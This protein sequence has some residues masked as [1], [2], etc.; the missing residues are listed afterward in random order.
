MKFVK[1]ALTLGLASGLLFGCTNNNADRGKNNVSPV[2]YNNPNTNTDNTNNMDRVSYQ[3][4]LGPGANVNYRDRDNNL[5]VN[6]DNT[7]GVNRDNNL[8]TDVN[9]NR[10]YNNRSNYRIAKEAADRVSKL[11]EVRRAN[12][13]VTGNNAYVAV[14]LNDRSRN[15]LPKTFENKISKE[16]K[17]ADNTIDNVY[18]TTNP[19]FYNR[20]TDFGNQVQEGHPVKGLYDQISDAVKRVFPNNR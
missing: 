4:N 13:L 5:D 9:Y 8:G 1:T 14:L 12:V 16:V 18:V 2:R 17:K 3:D 20:V 10:N 6:R 15:E 7:F 11:K 19:D